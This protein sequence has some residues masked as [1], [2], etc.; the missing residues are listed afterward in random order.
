MNTWWIVFKKELRE[1]WIG[2]KALNLIAAFTILLSIYTYTTV[3]GSVE[4]FVPPKEMV[5]ELVKLVMVVSVFMGLIIGADSLS[6]ERE[7]ATLE[8]L[9]LTPASRRQIVVG[10]FLAAVSPWPVAMAIAIPYMRVLSQGDEVFGPAVLWGAVLG[11][12]LTPGFTALGMLVS[13]WCSNNKSSMFISLVIYLLFLLPTQ[14]SGHAQGGFMGLLFQKVNPMGAP[15]VFLAMLLVNNRTMAETRSWLWSPI[16]FAVVIF[17]LLFWYVSGGLRLEPGKASRLE[18]ARGRALGV[19]VLAGLMGLLP[20]APLVAQGATQAPQATVEIPGH[21]GLTISIDMGAKV[22]QAGATILYNTVITNTS[23]EA[24]PPMI[25]A[26]NIINLNA[27][28]D[29]VDPEDWS[30]E[31]TQ[32]RD[33]LGPGESATLSWRINAI[34]DGDFM[35][36]MVCIPAPAGPEATTQPVASSGIHLTVMANTQLNPGGVLP[37]A[38]GGPVLLGLFIFLVYRHRRRQIDAGEPA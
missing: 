33:A 29:V 35:V 12:A 20:G 38:I 25:V 2:G 8:A 24:S 26:M 37:Y 9:L 3:Q 11:T 6:G 4:N 34:L 13:F 23:T 30:P 16:L 7:R 21:Q 36:Y 32:Y 18:F 5:F 10:K 31:R 19:I 27:Q 15:R 17:V 14:L 1:T 28:G 22:V